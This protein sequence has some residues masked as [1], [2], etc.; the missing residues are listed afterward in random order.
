[1]MVDELP[2]G[3][4]VQVGVTFASGIG[5]SATT[6]TR[7]FGVPLAWL[8]HF[9][10]TVLQLPNVTVV[11]YGRG[12]GHVPASKG[13]TLALL[14]WWK[15]PRGQLVFEEIRAGSAASHLTYFSMRVRHPNDWTE[16]SFVLWVMQDEAEYVQHEVHDNREVEA[17]SQIQ[18]SPASRLSTI[19]EEPSNVTE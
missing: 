1:T 11:I 12:V 19:T 8:S 4:S 16:I 17:S 14:M 6:T 3:K 9:A 7:V 15:G 13:Y 18:S 5:Q 2:A 10:Y